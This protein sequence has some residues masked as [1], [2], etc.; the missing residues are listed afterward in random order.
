MTTPVPPIVL[1]STCKLGSVF[2]FLFR[3]HAP[4]FLLSFFSSGEE[5]LEQAERGRRRGGEEGFEEQRKE[6]EIEKRRGQN[7]ICRYDYLDICLCPLA[8]LFLTFP[9]AFSLF[10]F[11]SFPWSATGQSLVGDGFPV[12]LA[13]HVCVYVCLSACRSLIF[14]FHLLLSLLFPFLHQICPL[15]SWIRIRALT[16]WNV[17]LLFWTYLFPYNELW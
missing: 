1:I 11:L 5:R 7:W 14:F 15:P 6:G 8:V 10:L 13:T 4:Y 3:S 17:V 2:L 16:T 12:C 9:H